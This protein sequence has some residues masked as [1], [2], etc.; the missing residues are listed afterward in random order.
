MEKWR[1]HETQGRRQVGVSSERQVETTTMPEDGQDW[2]PGGMMN[3][4]MEERNQGIP[5]GVETVLYCTVLGTMEQ[6]VRYKE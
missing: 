5:E 3:E 2:K 1:L 4:R 6:V